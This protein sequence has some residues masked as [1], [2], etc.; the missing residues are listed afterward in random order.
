MG[1]KIKVH[2]KLEVRSIFNSV[3]PVIKLEIDPLIPFSE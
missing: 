2:I 3:V 1:N